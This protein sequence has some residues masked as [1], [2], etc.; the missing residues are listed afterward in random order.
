[1]AETEAPLDVVVPDHLRSTI[2]VGS[3]DVH[4]VA[5]EIVQALA[6]SAFHDREPRVARRGP[7]LVRMTDRGELEELTLPS[8][9]DEISRAAIC[10]RWNDK[11]VKTAKPPRDV[12][13]IVLDR[14]TKDYAG[15]HEV[16]RVV[17]APV[18]DA[19]GRL[20][21]ESGFDRASGI[22]LRPAPGLTNLRISS[23]I[24]S[25]YKARDYLMR[26]L[27]DDFGFT[28]QAD[29]ANAFAYLITPAVLPFVDGPTPLFPVLGDDH[30]VGKTE[31]ARALLVPTCGEIA[32]TPPL[33]TADEWRKNITTAL[34]AGVP[35]V[36]FDNL[37]KVLDTGSLAVALTA[38]KWTDRVLGGN[39][40]VTLPI[41]NVWGATA[42][43]LEVSEELARRSVPIYLEAGSVKP[44]DRPKD[45]FRHPDL[46]GWTCANRKQLL[47]AVLTIVAYW[48]EGPGYEPVMTEDGPDLVQ[49]GHEE[50]GVDAPPLGSFDRWHR[51]LGGILWAVDVEGFLG[52]LNRIR[53]ENIGDER[54]EFVAFVKAWYALNREP[55]TAKELL[56]LG[57]PA[58]S[59]RGPPR[60]HPT[61]ARRGF[62]AAETARRITQ[63]FLPL[64]RS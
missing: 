31:L 8:L 18:L 21:I 11:E 45:A 2:D 50:W 59:M 14:D 33:G 30:G 23:D 54:G 3:T 32:V 40:R 55:M 62:L 20:V 5:D 19:T 48:H 57:T 7:E 15:I 43:N 36:V 63:W 49:A 22:W 10:M 17:D 25:A 58:R 42:S 1:M 35:A 56:Q 34:M 64:G 27:L 29:R 47:E 4:V 6:A 53:T 12:V 51:V 39:K 46:F 52:N 24:D 44:S 37:D 13:N 9:S 60:C 61:R 26:E 28:E 38:R 41:E 16:K